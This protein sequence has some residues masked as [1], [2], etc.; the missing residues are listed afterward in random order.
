MVGAPVPHGDNSIPFDSRGPW[1][2]GWCFTL[3]DPIGPL[4]EH[5]ECEGPIQTAGGAAHPAAANASLEPIVPRFH[6]GL[7]FGFRFEDVIERA[8]NAVAELMTEIA[9]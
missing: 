8:C 6:R 9:T 2:C 1:R 3:G 7:Q 4:G 5:L